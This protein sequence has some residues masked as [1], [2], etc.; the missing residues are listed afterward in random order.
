MINVAEYGCS[1]AILAPGVS[2]LNQ[3][4]VGPFVGYNSCCFEAA[5]ASRGWVNVERGCMDVCGA[6]GHP[7]G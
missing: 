5:V 1:F 4:V 7:C 6:V 3:V 2:Y